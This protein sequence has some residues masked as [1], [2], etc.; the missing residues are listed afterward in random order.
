MDL[1]LPCTTYTY[2]PGI[3]RING[4]TEKPTERPFR[5]PSEVKVRDTIFKTF[6]TYYPQLFNPFNFEKLNQIFFN[7]KNPSILTG[8][9]RQSDS[10]TGREIVDYRWIT[11]NEWLDHLK[12][13]HDVDNRTFDVH[14]TV[15]KIFRDDLDPNR[16]W[17]IVRENWKTLDAFGKI[18]Y[19]DN[20]FQFYNFDFTTDRVLKDFKI[21]YRLWFYEYQYDDLETGIKRHEKLKR[22]ITTY[23]RNGIKSMS[24][25]LNKAIYKYFVSQIKIP[26][27]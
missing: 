16:Y 12:K 26:E 23:F 8:T 2:F 24:S 7:K 1:S 14:A 27:P 4:S 13:L 9:V 21:Y 18:V 22:D 6:S 20:T 5:T 25:T 11:T 10:L 15:M 3:A 17:A 19:E